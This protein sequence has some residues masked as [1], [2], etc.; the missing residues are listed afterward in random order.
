M[1]DAGQAISGLLQKERGGPRDDA[2]RFASAKPTEEQPA[3]PVE[4]TERPVETQE[5]P[6]DNLEFDDGQSTGADNNQP[7]IDMPKSWSSSDRDE[8]SKLTPEAK[9]IVQR[10]EQQREAGMSKLASQLKAK[11]TEVAKV[12]EQIETERKQLASQAGRYASEAVR[13][14][15]S[16]FGDVKDPGQL[17]ATDPARFLRY[18]AAQMAVGQ[19]VQEAQQYEQQQAEEFSKAMLEFRKTENEKVAERLK[20]DTPEKR[21]AFETRIIKAAESDGIPIS[22]LQQYTAEELAIYDDALKYRAA[23]A[24]RAEKEKAVKQPP[25][26]VRPG[27]PSA[28][29]A[30]EQQEASVMKNL[31]QTGT[32]DAA[33]AAFKLRLGGR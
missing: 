27:S 3:P 21:Q 26:V 2:G 22:R 24:K 30:K 23:I 4:A 32:I 8:W 31:R 14:F 10:R 12:L 13:K 9:A 18:Q 33:A 28:S 7:D 19:A 1:H 6:D 11:E 20:L 17:A 5:S 25:K 29:P 16:E 15:Q